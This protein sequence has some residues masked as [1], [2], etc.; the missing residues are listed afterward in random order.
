MRAPTLIVLGDAPCLFED[1]K[2]LKDTEADLMAVNGSGARYPWTIRFWT[3]YHPERFEGW[4]LTRKRIGGNLDFRE[5]T[6]KTLPPPGLSGSST[7]LGVLAGLKFG[8]RRVVLAGG[9]LDD[10]AYQ[11]YR[12]GWKN[13]A[14]LLRGR[15]WSV[16]GWT[17]EFLEKLNDASIDHRS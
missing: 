4:I 7:L 2:Q 9:P 11:R 8:Y 17:G 13:E 3:T 16:S 14:D 1:L 10:K 12:K 6:D 15:V 5:V